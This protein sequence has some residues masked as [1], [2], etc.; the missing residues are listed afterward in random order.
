MNFL[1]E[2]KKDRAFMVALPIFTFEGALHF[3][4]RMSHETDSKRKLEQPQFPWVSHH[5]K[6]RTLLLF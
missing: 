1:V 2:S 4:D 6:V 3:V 5:E